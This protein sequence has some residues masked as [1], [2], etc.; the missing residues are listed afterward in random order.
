MIRSLSNSLF[1]QAPLDLVTP[2]TSK[3]KAQPLPLYQSTLKTA[4]PNRDDSNTNS[5]E[6]NQNWFSKL[7]EDPTVIQRL[8]DQHAADDQHCD[9]D[10]KK[11]TPLKL[12]SV[13]K[14]AR[15]DEEKIVSE[16]SLA[17]KRRIDFTSSLDCPH[18][19]KQ[20]PLGGQWKVRKHIHNEHKDLTKKA[21]IVCEICNETFSSQ[22]VFLSHSEMHR[23]GDPWNCN[24]CK[25]RF[26]EM[27]LLGEVTVC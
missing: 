13:I 18:C 4:L 21:A 6:D 17:K 2:S 16:A 12:S 14:R 8:V 24:L 3:D 22:S 20:F 9:H 15:V 5:T 25:R 27:P 11:V 1:L 10:K 7:K 19:D 26:G 23:V